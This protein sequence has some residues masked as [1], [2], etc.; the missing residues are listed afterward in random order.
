MASG[1]LTAQTQNQGLEGMSR[2]EA[3][4]NS[5]RTGAPKPPFEIVGL[6]HNVLTTL[7]VKPLFFD[8]SQQ[9][10][11]TLKRGR[12][13][14]CLSVKVRAWSC[15]AARQPTLEVSLGAWTWAHFTCCSPSVLAPAEGT[16]SFGEIPK[17]PLGRG[18]I[19]AHAPITR[20][21]KYGVHRCPT[22][23]LPG[24]RGDT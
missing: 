16:V 20:M 14:R 17:A 3:K 5:L 15:C 22:H 19:T 12:G 1:H 11:K 21:G 2:G 8:L 23:C 18:R 10:L 13:A 24:T 4:L 7:H 6:S 9:T